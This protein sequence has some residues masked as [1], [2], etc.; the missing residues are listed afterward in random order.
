MN[1]EVP[2]EAFGL[3]VGALFTQVAHQRPDEVAVEQDG[4]TWT[5]RELDERTNRLAHV[6]R[7]RGVG[8]GDRVAILSENRHEYLELELA[9]AKVGAIVACLNWRLADAE[10]RHCIGLTS[11]T[12]LVVSPRFRDVIDRLAPAI[13]EMLVLGEDLEARLE[14]ASTK[15]P[16]SVVDAEDGLVILYTSGTTGLPKGAVISHRALAARFA[17]F[18][19]VTGAGP[20]DAFVA[21]APLFH[22]ASTDQSLI[23]LLLGGRVVVVDGL[24]LDVIG[25]AIERHRLGW[26]VA[27][28]GM[29]D[30]LIDHLVSRAVV[31]RGV[32]CVGAMADLVPLQQIADLTRLLACPYVNSFGSTECGLPPASAAMLAPGQIPHSLSKRTTPL[33][34]TRLVDAED[35]DVPDGVPGE[36]LFRGPT[37]FSGYWN[38]PEVNGEDFRGGWF[39]TG[40]MFVRNADA[41]LDFVDRVKYMIKTG[42]ENVYPAEIERL[43]LAEPLVADAAV[44]RRM[45]ERWGE[46]P[47]AFV[48]RLDESLTPEALLEAL[49]GRLAG[50]KI[51]KEIHFVAEADFPR[52]T[53]GKIQRHEVEAWLQ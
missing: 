8:R 28:P 3:T 11:P 14:G 20:D 22:M 2:S 18:C 10:L 5:F 35:R 34:L 44:V 36:L 4:T 45:D 27:M 52:S 42:G 50:Y 49:R 6:I 38:A 53:T 21:W 30:R 26:L 15:P 46:V 32:K 16:V 48:A 43:L 19:M 39:H 40:D 37:L 23:T 29:V 47:V 17:V 33:G 41:T 25:A 12:V 31:V 1:P 24:D 9:A 7:E 13:D 51:P